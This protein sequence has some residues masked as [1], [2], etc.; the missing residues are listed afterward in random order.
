MVPD[1]HGRIGLSGPSVDA[2]LGIVAATAKLA[3]LT[4]MS[5]NEVFPAS[6]R[7]ALFVACDEAVEDWNHRVRGLAAAHGGEVVERML[8]MQAAALASEVARF[9]TARADEDTEYLG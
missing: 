5:R 4:Q 1:G 9:L 8:R 3:L 2:Q 7:A 6:M